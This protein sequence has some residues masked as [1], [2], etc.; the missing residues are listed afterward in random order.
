M[1]CFYVH[2][3]WRRHATPRLRFEAHAEQLA[4]P[5][6]SG[7]QAHKGKTAKHLANIIVRREHTNQDGRAAGAPHYLYFQSRKVQQQ[8]TQSEA[9]I[10]SGQHIIQ[11]ATS[12]TMQGEKSSYN[13]TRE[14]GHEWPLA[15]C[16]F[17]Y[18][19]HRACLILFP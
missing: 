3:S 1:G 4:Q 19:A 8:Q 13:M 11:Q 7:G 17:C 2:S 12:V 15:G 5:H 6:M 18:A 10:S 16:A 9:C 14:D